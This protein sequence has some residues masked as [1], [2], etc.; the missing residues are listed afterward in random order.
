MKIKQLVAEESCGLTLLGPKERS[1]P[2]KFSSVCSIPF[3]PEDF[4]RQ[5]FAIQD[6][7][8]NLKRSLVRDDIGVSAVP[9][10]F[11]TSMEVEPAKQTEIRIGLALRPQPEEE[12]VLQIKELRGQGPH[13]SIEWFV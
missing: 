10:I 3:R 8:S 6:L 7:T 1:Q 11:A 9:L 2:S 5:N 12:G 13:A 4:E